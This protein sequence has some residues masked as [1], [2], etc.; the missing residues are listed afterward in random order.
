MHEAQLLSGL[1]LR[2]KG[3]WGYSA[4][5][6]DECRSE[7]TVDESRFGSDGY[8]CFVALV[9]NSIV[10]FYALEKLSA[11]AYELDALFV[12]PE[13]I[14]SGV[15][16][17]LVQHA[18]QRLSERGAERL[19]IQGDPNAT[20][21]YVAAGARTIGSRKSGSIPGRELPLFEIEIVKS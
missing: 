12:E 3:Y 19:L 1:A 5:F 21:F 16:R 15:G 20:G 2:S 6:L 10:G 7:L 13:R 9:G 8:Q 11:N 4:D 18:V 17:F 14:G